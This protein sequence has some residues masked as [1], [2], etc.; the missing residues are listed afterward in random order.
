[1][2]VALIRN[3][4]AMTLPPIISQGK[5][6]LKRYRRQVV[7]YGLIG[8]GVLLIVGITW[9]VPALHQQ[10]GKVLAKALPTP[11]DTYDAAAPAAQAASLADNVTSLKEQVAQ[12][13]KDLADQKKALA[14]A[15]QNAAAGQESFKSA[16]AAQAQDLAKAREEMV[17]AGQTVAQSDMQD[18]SDSSATPPPKA[19]DTVSVSPSSLVNINSASADQLDTLPGIGPSYAQ[20]IVDY[21]EQHG[22]FKSIDDLDNVSGIGVSTI[23]KLKDL[24]TI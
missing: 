10:A 11:A 22:D 18:N 4:T 15:N 20:R 7:R 8:F 24:I 12:L 21:R 19:A 5:N 17:T 13:E 2:V 9:F 1:M 16:L 23:A 3:S 6:W 14:T